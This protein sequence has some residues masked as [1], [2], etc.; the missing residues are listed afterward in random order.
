MPSKCP[1]S[2]FR[3]NV[4]VYIGL[5]T[6][7]RVETD[8]TYLDETGNYKKVT[9]SQRGDVLAFFR[10]GF[11]GEF[12]RFVFGTGYE[13]WGNKGACDHYAYFKVGV[14]FGDL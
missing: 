11:G 2:S 12:K 5:C 7:P 13:L 4:D 10:V 14:R 3:P 8:L 1:S 9:Q 6:P